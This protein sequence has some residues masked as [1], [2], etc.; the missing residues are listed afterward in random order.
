ML[1]RL[2]I[3]FLISMHFSLFIYQLT[4]K[5]LSISVNILENY[6]KMLLLSFQFI[7]TALNV[8]MVTVEKFLP[9]NLSLLMES[10]PGSNIHELGKLIYR[11]MHDLYWEVRD[12]ALELLLVCTEISFISELYFCF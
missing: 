7:V 6:S 2:F 9:P 11:K 1:I 12:S 8:I 4:S 10:K 5:L 3:N